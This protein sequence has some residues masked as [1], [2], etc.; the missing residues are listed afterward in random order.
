[1]LYFSLVHF[2]VLFTFSISVLHYLYTHVTN[3]N[4]NKKFT[5]DVQWSSAPLF[6]DSNFKTVC[7]Y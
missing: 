2:P 3:R 1:M 6:Y 7:S 5:V 4:H